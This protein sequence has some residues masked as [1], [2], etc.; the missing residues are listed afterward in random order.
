MADH[1][2]VEEYLKTYDGIVSFRDNLSQVFMDK[3]K[4][5]HGCRISLAS[6]HKFAKM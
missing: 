5:R 3:G 6:N 2:V 1:P 4:S